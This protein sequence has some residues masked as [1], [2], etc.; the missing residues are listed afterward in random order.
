[1]TKCTEAVSV[2]AL[3]KTYKNGSIRALNNIDLTIEQGEIFG[4]IGPN[5][6][7]KTTLIG[8]LL[9]LIRPD[10][11]EVK[12]LGKP[13]DYL[14]VLRR[15]GYMPERVMFEHWMTA[16]QFL[17]FHHGLAKVEV[18]DKAKKIESLLDLVQLSKAAR[19]R[20]LKTFSRGMLQRLNLA[21]SLV[22]DPRL[23]M[24]DEPTLGLDPTGVDVVREVIIELQKDGVT[25]VINSH[26]LDEIERLCSRVAMISAGR[27]KSI[28][29]MNQGENGS[30]ILF[31]SWSTE[32]L[33][34][35]LLPS[36]ERACG[37]SSCEP[38]EVEQQWGRFLIANRGDAAILI[39][40]LIEEGIPVD[41]A[42]NEK[43][44]LAGLFYEGGE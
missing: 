10:S 17:D 12:V 20:K 2:K 15:V 5:G 25:A 29:Q 11:G 7:G 30:Y 23:V 39:S 6:A 22:G 40:A 42:R 31:T 44:S 24:L 34:G 43:K 38:L 14:S 13:A 4:L 3:K 35:S 19:D 21:Q 1:M 36:I 41:E 27:I 8:C 33:N 26:H 32:N 37:K 16:R 28:E 18:P 9:S